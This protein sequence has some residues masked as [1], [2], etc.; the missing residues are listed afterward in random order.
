MSALP[1]CAYLQAAICEGYTGPS[2][3]WVNAKLFAGGTLGSGCAFIYEGACYLLPAN[4]Q[5][6]YPPQGAAFAAAI[7]GTYPGC[8]ACA[9]ADS[10]YPP[11]LYFDCSGDSY[12]IP[13]GVPLTIFGTPGAGFTLTPDVGWIGVGE[14]QTVPPALGAAY[15]GT[16]GQTGEATAYVFCNYTGTAGVS[17]KIST[18]PCDA[19]VGVSATCTCPVPQG[20]Y[21]ATFTCQAPLS[22]FQHCIGCSEPSQFSGSTSIG[23]FTLQSAGYGTPNCPCAVGTYDVDCPDGAVSVSVG[24]YLDSGAYFFSLSLDFGECN[25]DIPGQ[26]NGIPFS[27]HPSFTVS[28]PCSADGPCPGANLGL[29]TI[30]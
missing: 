7:G 8:S 23:S 10:V 22:C 18:T 13:S 6:A 12:T 17:G 1:V 15:S 30:A 28:V 27:L 24:V 2:P 16:I 11:S 29:V 26:V 21:T 14:S 20:T 3:I 25:C 5:P 4:P 19:A 9:C